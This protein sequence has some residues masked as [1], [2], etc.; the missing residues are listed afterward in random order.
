MHHGLSLYSR[1]NHRLRRS[2]TCTPSR[3]REDLFSDSAFA[4]IQKIIQQRKSI[5]K[6][7]SVMMLAV[8]S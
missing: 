4:I 1:E 7:R 3:Y 5:G 8:R 2:G 6:M